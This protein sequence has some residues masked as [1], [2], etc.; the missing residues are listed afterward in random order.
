M[1]TGSCGRLDGQQMRALTVVCFLVTLLMYTVLKINDITPHE[2][3]AQPC[4]RAVRLL[5][6]HG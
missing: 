5:V 3:T 6:T 1:L 2:E 4:D